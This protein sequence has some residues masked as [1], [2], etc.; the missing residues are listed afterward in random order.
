MPSPSSLNMALSASIC[1][2]RGS[3]RKQ[4]VSC[5]FVTCWDGHSKL[6]GSSLRKATKCVLFPPLP[7]LTTWLSEPGMADPL[8]REVMAVRRSEPAGMNPNPPPTTFLWAALRVPSKET[9]RAA[10]A[11]EAAGFHGCCQRSPTP[12]PPP[13]PTTAPRQAGRHLQ[14]ATTPPCRAIPCHEV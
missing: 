2:L 6:D 10:G 3:C 12:P 4:T 8:E 7:R 5:V 9:T 11:E 14:M 1:F 13:W